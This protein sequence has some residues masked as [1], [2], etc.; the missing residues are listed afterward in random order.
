MK[1]RAIRYL[2]AGLLLL[3]SFAMCACGADVKEA[4]AAE[5]SVRRQGTETDSDAANGTER[6]ETEEAGGMT[7]VESEGKT[8]ALPAEKEREDHKDGANGFAFRLA[9][10]MVQD[11]NEG[12]NLIVSPYSVW[13]PLSALA[14]GTDREA[15]GELLSVLGKSGADVEE[16]NEEVKGMLAVLQKDEQAEWNRENG[17]GDFESPLQ[18]ANALFVDSNAAVN[19][20]LEDIFVENYRGKLFQAD[21]GEDSAVEMV[22]RWAK[23]ST[24]GKIDRIIEEFPPDTRAAIANAIYFSD[25][26]TKEFSVQNT[27]EDVFYSAAGEERVPFMNQEFDRMPYYEDE[28]MQAAALATATGGRLFVLL[29]KEGVSAEELL[30]G[31]DAEKFA[32]LEE[33]EERTV[34]FSMPRFLIESDVFSLKEVLMRMGVP[35]MDE[36][37][38]HLDKILDKEALSLS[39]AVQKAMIEV[40]EKGMTAA[41][42]TAIVMQRCSLIEGGEPV[43]MKCDRPFAFLLTAYGGVGQ[44]VLFCGIVNRIG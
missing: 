16:L 18:I 14:N 30:S 25:G 41:A 33:T 34:Q 7:D 37:T 10:Q 3:Q 28:D 5:E 31:M 15:V 23:E 32:L 29:P 11:L 4:E 43:K 42:V 24:K 36:N 19:P 27:Q 2:A 1:N 9:G 21:F 26:W 8:R 44:Q 6:A 40:D 39:C 17:A 38:P 13:L 22:N 35:L 20:E 12:E